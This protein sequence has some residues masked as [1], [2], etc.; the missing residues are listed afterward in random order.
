M[1]LLE[2]VAGL[3]HEFGTDDFVL[4]G[5]GNTSAK[6][7]E[8]LW[9]KPSGTTLRE[10]APD[11]FLALDRSKV[12]Q[13]YDLE[14]P[15]ETSARET[16]VKDH[17]QTTVLPGESG[18]PSVEAP[19]HNVFDATFVVHT[20]MTLLNGLTCSRNGAAA[21]RELFP[22]ALWMEYVDP[23]YTLCMRARE[24]VDAFASAHGRQPS[25]VIM[26]N[27]GV[28]VA[29]DSPEAVRQIHGRLVEALGV[30]YENAGVPVERVDPPML[31][32]ERTAA[33]SVQLAEIFGEDARCTAFSGAFAP[34]AGPL[35]PDHLVYAKAYAYDGELTP[36]G[37]AAFR[38]RWGYAPRV[39][40]TPD[41]VVGIGPSQ[42]VADM[43]LALARDGA[44]VCRLAEAF[45]GVSFMGD[46]EREFIE[47]WEVEAYRSKVSLG[48][49]S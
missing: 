46:R 14:A 8:T 30:H 23:G 33:L 26:K 34:A 7:E 17:M 22:E 4:G 48:D 24:E 19:L 32:E 31:D 28:F 40:A 13:L 43:A 10:I 41:A 12:A 29:E 49:G 1:N 38:E 20:H 2:A 25:L 42:K 44:L 5:G 35:S 9:V 37:A 6:D 27:H 16:L 39:V 47:N 3:S 36:P 21:C 15:A 18:R 45:D 11:Q